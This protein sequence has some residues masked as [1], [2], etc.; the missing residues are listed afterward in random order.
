[1]FGQALKESRTVLGQSVVG[2][3]GQGA[4]A[5][6]LNRSCDSAEKKTELV[7]N[8]S[9]QPINGSDEPEWEKLP[10]SDTKAP[11]LGARAASGS[12]SK[13]APGNR[14]LPPI[15]DCN[16]VYRAVFRFKAVSATTSAITAATLSFAF[17]AVASN[18][19][20]LY[21]IASAFRIRKVRVYP[22]ASATGALVQSFLTWDPQISAFTKDD[23]RDGSVPAGVTVTGERV[24]TP[25]KGTLGAFWINSGVVTTLQ[26]FSIANPTGSIVDLEVDWQL[27]NVVAQFP[28][29][30]FGAGMV[31]GTLY[32]GGL[33]SPRIGSANY[34]AQD[35]PAVP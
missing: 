2:V 16:P 33:D 6:R 21:P 23:V 3:L 26:I 30:T 12:L 24:Y 5:P 14:S 28:R 1:M 9:F 17:G 31:A 11:F 20:D 7:G 8:N 4:S 13:W 18:A 22:A 32:Y 10:P 29:L 15:L 25:P 35:R 27:S 34:Q 19:T